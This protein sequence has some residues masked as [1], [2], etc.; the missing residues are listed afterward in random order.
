MHAHPK[1]GQVEQEADAVDAHT[2]DILQFP[3]NR[4]GVF[5]SQGQV[6]AAFVHGDD[7]I[8]HVL[9]AATAFNAPLDGL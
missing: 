6:L 4:A 3:H 8:T 9:Q 5:Q 2:Q 7:G 1:D